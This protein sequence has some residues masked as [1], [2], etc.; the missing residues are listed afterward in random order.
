MDDHRIYIWNIQTCLNNCCRD[1][2]INITIDKIIHDL[3]Q[4]CFLHLS[5][6]KGNICFRNKFL[7]LRSNISD[8]ADTVIN[9]IY[10]SMSGQLSDNCFP[11][12][13]II[14]FAYKCL[15]RLSVIWRFF[16]DAHISDPDQAH[17]QRS[18]NRRCRQRQNIYAFF[19]FLD[20]FLVCYAKSL[21]FIHNQQPQILIFHIR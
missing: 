18:W 14:V 13:F 20:F 5:M 19:H 3:L 1:Q 21:L 2:N 16:Q 12:H 15:D 10:L 4:L 8:I 6:C 7:H 9:I 17:M 11:D